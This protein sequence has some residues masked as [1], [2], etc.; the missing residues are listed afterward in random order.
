MNNLSTQF[1]AVERIQFLEELKRSIKIMHKAS[2]NGLSLVSE[3][4]RI[5]Q[6]LGYGAWNLM[7]AHVAECD[8]S[9]FHSLMGACESRNLIR[10]CEDDDVDFDEFW[11]DGAGDL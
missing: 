8:G 2:D 9:H 11:F 5:A 1:A 6:S 4:N 7:I 3:Q 10:T